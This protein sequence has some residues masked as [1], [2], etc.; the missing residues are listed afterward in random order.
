MY[1]ISSTPSQL[2]GANGAISVANYGYEGYFAFFEQ[3]SGDN[4]ILVVGMNLSTEALSQATSIAS[5]YY[6]STM[7]ASSSAQYILGFSSSGYQMIMVILDI[8]SFNN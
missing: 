7:Q 2:Y 4:R 3:K 1:Y 6:P 5:D 8:K